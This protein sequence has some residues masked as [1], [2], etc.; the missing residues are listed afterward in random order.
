MKKLISE[1]ISISISITERL[2]MIAF[3]GNIPYHASYQVSKLGI[4]K[5]TTEML[6]CG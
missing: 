3:A 5:S 4:L 1:F 2:Q 6:M